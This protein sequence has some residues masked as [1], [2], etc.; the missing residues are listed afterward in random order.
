MPTKEEIKESLVEQ[1]E[2]E[3]GF[4]DIVDK[5]SEEIDFDL[6]VEFILERIFEVWK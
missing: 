3:L 4:Y 6:I 5:R 2:N 1:C